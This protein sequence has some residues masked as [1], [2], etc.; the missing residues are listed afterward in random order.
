MSGPP[1]P[2]LTTPGSSYFGVYEADA[3]PSADGAVISS[4]PDASGGA[5]PLLGSAGPTFHPKRWPGGRPS[6]VFDKSISQCLAGSSPSLWRFLSDG[7]PFTL[8]C[9]WR[10]L[11]TLPTGSYEVLLSTGDASSSSLTPATLLEFGNDAGYANGLDLTTYRG[12]PGAAL[13]VVRQGAWDRS[14]ECTCA[15]F[16]GA[17]GYLDS[18]GI[19]VAS[20]IRGHLQ[21][22]ATPGA[23]LCVGRDAG[24]LYPFGGEVAAV[25]VVK[26]S[27]NAVDLA[28]VNAYLEAKWHPAGGVTREYFLDA[29]NVTA[30]SGVSLSVNRPAKYAG[31]PVF[32]LAEVSPAVDLDFFGLAKFSDTDWRLWYS[33]EAKDQAP[34]YS[35]FGSAYATSTD[36]ISWAKPTLGQI[37]YGGSA[38]NNLFGESRYDYLSHVLYAPDEAPDRRF[39]M[40]VCQ[41]GPPDALT[42][43]IKLQRSADGV[44]GWATIKTLTTNPFDGEAGGLARR[45]DGRYVVT[46]LDGQDVNLRNTRLFASETPDPAGN[47]T[48]YGDVLMAPSSSH[49]FHQMFP[50]PCGPVWLGLQTVLNSA[51]P[52]A[53][54]LDLSLYVSRDEGFTWSLAADHFVP[55]GPAGSWDAR[56]MQG[57]ALVQN[58]AEWR[59]YYSGSNVDMFA[60]A[61][62]LYTKLGF[63]WAPAGRVGQ[64]SSTGTLTTRAL[65][66]PGYVLAADFAGALTTALLDAQGNVLVG[67]GD[68]DPWPGVTPLPDAICR[69]RFTL[70]GAS[71]YSYA[72]TPP[73]PPPPT[74]TETWAAS[75]GKV[76]TAERQADG[77]W[78]I[79]S[80]Q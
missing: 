52:P 37:P 38:A 43:G 22:T 1:L 29:G 69:V 67:Y 80:I 77:S 20:A 53:N 50:A 57:A 78:K 71:L 74:T 15:R 28:A 24:G 40:N 5:E 63:A 36:G 34:A 79:V 59:F 66:L 19:N 51:G 54:A 56:Q 60:G 41:Q 21:S 9:V 10:K 13:S 68:A 76:A 31:N 33:T 65:Y 46:A 73:P 58:G 47:W 12:T 4:W 72:L 6:L 11:V 26:G 30:A 61:N 35:A 75:G 3:L 17:T 2:T 8:F 14:A 49:Q 23:A 48:D 16:D 45:A 64:V 62:P 39:L 44:T 55:L 42:T 27:L 18:W 25:I 7:S 70:S 32:D